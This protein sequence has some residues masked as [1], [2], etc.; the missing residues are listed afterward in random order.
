MVKTEFN[1]S[2]VATASSNKAVLHTYISKTFFM[3]QGKGVMKDSSF[4][5]DF[6]EKVIK[7]FM[8]DIMEKK[9]TETQFINQV[10]KAQTKTYNHGQWKM[11]QREK[12]NTCDICSRTF[13][14]KQGVTSNKERMHENKLALK[15]KSKLINSIKLN[16]GL[17]RSDSVS[18]QSS[19]LP[20]KKLIVEKNKRYQP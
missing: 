14:S 6:F 17:S 3:I 7:Q 19:S 8:H 12:D 2:D 10:L 20:P 15:T 11:K 13:A 16:N 4:C 5:K 9:G 1:V 18:S